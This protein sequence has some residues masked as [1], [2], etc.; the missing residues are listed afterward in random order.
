MRCD[1]VPW[2]EC[3]ASWRAADDGGAARA[4]GVRAG[5]AATRLRME[6][7]SQGQAGA[8]KR[9]HGAEGLVIERYSSEGLESPSGGFRVFPLLEEIY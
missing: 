7:V 6:L 1:A 4:G 5:L 2:L 8:A 9:Q 3:D